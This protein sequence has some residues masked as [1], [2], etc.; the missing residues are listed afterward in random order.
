MKYNSNNNNNNKPCC[1]NGEASTLA[2]NDLTCGLAVLVGRFLAKAFKRFCVVRILLASTLIED[3]GGSIN[4][5][6]LNII[7]YYIY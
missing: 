1:R 2:A 6:I 3:G 4:R 7:I 5:I